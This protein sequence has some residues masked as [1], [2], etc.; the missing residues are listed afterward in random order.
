M[1]RTNARLVSPVVYF[2]FFVASSLVETDDLMTSPESDLA[3]PTAFS[4]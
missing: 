4:A 2:R 3:S 1:L